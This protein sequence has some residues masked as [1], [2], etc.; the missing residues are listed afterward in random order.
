MKLEQISSSLKQQVLDYLT[1]TTYY[2][3]H[4]KLIDKSKSNK[5]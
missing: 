4:I 2:D 1:D 5:L 3:Q